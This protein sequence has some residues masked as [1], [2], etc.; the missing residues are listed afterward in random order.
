MR[1]R[2]R[3]VIRA[4]DAALTIH[5]RHST[6]F[7]AQLRH[8]RN[9]LQLVRAVE[10]YQRERP[11]TGGRVEHDEVERVDREWEETEARRRE[12]RFEKR[13]RSI[14]ADRRSSRAAL[15]ALDLHRLAVQRS[16]TLSTVGAGNVAPTRGGGD[17]VGPPQQQRLDD[18]PR[19]RETWT[20]IRA[21][22]ERANELLD[23][24]EGLSTVA[25]T[26]T[27]LG[28][29]KDRR[30]IMEGE[31]LSPV[32]TVEKLGSE[33]AGSPETFRRIRK[34]YDRTTLDGHHRL[35]L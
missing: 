6:L 26:T 7:A 2:A 10:R 9:C 34:R 20:V 3:R 25:A 15:T 8:D 28:V 4:I 31:G 1:Q 19:W 16:T 35:D 23:E 21:R 11:A 17:P 30:V 12:D 22:L 24:A 5:K 32:A 27:M 18:D 33:I 14:D 13:K 29:E